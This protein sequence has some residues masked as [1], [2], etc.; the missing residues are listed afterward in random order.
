[1]AERKDPALVD[2]TGEVSILVVDDEEMLASLLS[3][4]LEYEGWTVH[5]AGTGNRAI[6][7]ANELKPDVILLDIGLPDMDG[8]TVLRRIRATQ[9]LVPILFLTARDAVADRVAGLNAGADDYVTKPFDLAEVVARIQVLLRRGGKNPTPPDPTLTVGD[10]VLNEDSHAVTRAGQEITLTATEF[11]L[12]HYLMLNAGRVVSKSQILDHVWNYDFGGK[13][14][15]VELYIS[16]L[17]R[18]LGVAGLPPM[19]TTL[20]GVGYLLDVPKA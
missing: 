9:P 19:I 18:K 1:M 12:L 4:A 15:V 13:A 17:R 20:R 11:E 8:L 6:R 3:S 7:M 16:Y 10:L 14:N 5:T 2:P